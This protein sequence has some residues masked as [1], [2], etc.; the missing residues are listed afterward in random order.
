MSYAVSFMDNVGCHGFS[1]D[2]FVRNLPT[3]EELCSKVL[4]DYASARLHVFIANMFQSADSKADQQ[5]GNS[6]GKYK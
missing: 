6:Q 3:L 4:E 1:L 5:A 2:S